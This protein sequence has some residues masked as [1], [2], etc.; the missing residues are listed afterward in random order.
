MISINKWFSK[1][2]KR[3]LFLLGLGTI[4]VQI[5]F[6]FYI[7]IIQHR[8]QSSSVENLFTIANLALEQKNR[9][10]LESTF[11]VA[12]EELGAE[13]IILCKGTETIMKLPL[14]KSS[15]ENLP[16]INLFTK[17]LK[18]SA[19]GRPDY[20]FHFYLPALL[21]SRSYL[22]LF[23][24][25]FMF[26][27]LS[28]LIIL[29]VQRRFSEDILEPLE[30][31]LLSDNEINI[32]QLEELRNKI[33]KVRAARE[34]EAAANAILEHKTKVAHNIRSLVQTLKSLQSSIQEKLSP[35][36]KNLFNDVVEGIGDILTEFS[37]KSTPIKVNNT[38]S[39]DEAFFTNMNEINNKRTR[40]EVV[41]VIKSI[42]KQKRCELK[43]LNPDVSIS[44]KIDDSVS[45]SFID[46]EEAEF[47]SILSNII[48]NSFESRSSLA[49]KIQINVIKI[50]EKIEIRILDTGSGIPFEVL[51]SLF[52]RG[53]TSGKT[54]GTG[55]GLFHAK[56]F[57]NSWSGDIKVETTSSKGTVILLDIPCW[58]PA[59]FVL[60][61]SDTVVIVDDDQLVHDIWK[62]HI[63]M[64]EKGT[65]KMIISK[66]FLNP[67]DA[68][69]WI[70]N[71][72]IDYSQTTFLIDNDLG[73]NFESGSSLINSLGINEVAT[74]VTNRYDDK[75]LIS[76]CRLNNIFLLP[77]PFIFSTENCFFDSSVTYFES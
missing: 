41:D 14:G 10:I 15:C 55:Y 39:T 71:A 34:K 54:N 19:I 20:Q 66:F 43:S 9:P 53:T 67:V 12:I 57:L 36:K 52:H 32:I 40:I 33:K 28:I 63:S 24:I 45:Y 18:F 42:V 59:P 6:I 30:N 49:N 35:A 73:K 48:N 51:K 62:A 7:S 47:R 60:S 72:A 21:L 75:N 56:S 25:T 5:C 3:P 46:V 50:A 1:N 58:H 70:S 38:Y 76:F 22:V 68:E 16:E 8:D 17:H 2:A 77:K 37:V 27:V 64:W 69:K 74:L 11:D 29:K 4:V 61:N 44:Y 65:G 13:Q 31:K 23:S 26:F